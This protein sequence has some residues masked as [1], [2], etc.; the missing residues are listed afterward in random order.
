MTRYS[1]YLDGKWVDSRARDINRMRAI[2]IKRFG[3][4]L[5]TNKIKEIWIAKDDVMAGC[6][7]YSRTKQRFEYG[8]DHVAYGK[9]NPESGRLTYDR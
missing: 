8:D 5:R 7:S 1:Y 6:L 2:L 9:V 4:E 3:P